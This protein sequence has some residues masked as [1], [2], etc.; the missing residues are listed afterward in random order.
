V[1]T[2]KKTLWIFVLLS[3]LLAACGGD[4]NEEPAA[5]APTTADG[6]ELFENLGCVACH[7]TSGKGPGPSLAGLYGETIALEDGGSVT[8]DDQFIRTSILDPHAHTHA[9]YQPI[10]PSF[11]GRVTEEELSLLV[12]YIRSLS[13]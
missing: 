1:N 2:L 11:E 7:Q 9:G 3:V 6:S 10:M 12:E 8:V 13:E 5:S 4:R